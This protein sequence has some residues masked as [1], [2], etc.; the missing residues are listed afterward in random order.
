MDRIIAEAIPLVHSEQVKK[1]GVFWRQNLSGFAV[2]GTIGV[3]GTFGVGV[4][5][6]EAFE[7][8]RG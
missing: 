7:L 8:Y 1:G 5:I 4:L 6:S 3:A 2:V